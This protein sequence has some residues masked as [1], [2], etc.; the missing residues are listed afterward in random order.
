MMVTDSG[1]V[2]TEPMDS[3]IPLADSGAVN[4][5]PMDSGVM[6]DGGV[7]EEWPPD[8]GVGLGWV[9]EVVFFT[10]PLTLS[11]NECAEVV[12]GVLEDE[13]G[14]YASFDI[15]PSVTV[16]SGEVRN[17]S[18]VFHHTELF[19]SCSEVCEENEESGFGQIFCDMP[20]G[21]MRVLRYSVKGNAP[22]I[23][24]I[25]VRARHGVD[26]PIFGFQTLTI[27]P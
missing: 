2:N 20:G 27:V 7:S 22:G 17:N 18:V 26:S 1:A 24:Q 12:I 11:V 16:S 4:T 23:Y 15:A 8:L 13:D 25:W 19:F 3:G 10:E 9:S 5:E 6:V 14:L 21:N